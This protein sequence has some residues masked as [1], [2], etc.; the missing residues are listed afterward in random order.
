MLI[1]LLLLIA[2][3]GESQGRKAT[4]LNLR[5][6]GY[7]L[8]KENVMPKAILTKAVMITATLL[9]APL[10][11]HAQSIT[12][13]YTG[14]ITSIGSLL[15]GDGITVGSSLNGSFTYETTASTVGGDGTTYAYYPISSYSM[16]LVRGSGLPNFEAST[17]PTSFNKTMMVQNDKQNGSATLPADGLT[18]RSGRSTS[19]SLN[20][21]SNPYM[22]T[23]IYKKNV[24]GHLWGDVL[25]PSITD[26]STVSL[27]DFNAASWNWMD[28]N[29][30]T[31]AL[32]ASFFDDQIRWNIDSFCVNCGVSEVP[33]PAAAF[34]FA[35]ALLG[36]LGLR[37][38][39]KVTTA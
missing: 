21:H 30:N 5:W 36:F 18:V 12:I 8:I 39:A 11:I 10:S 24:N 28:F 4:D 31:A 20:G 3:L 25:S 34:M 23:G 13:S 38:K 32:G 33:V 37:R 35:P 15:Q 22:Q 2:K 26:W 17:T 14:S 19:S 29:L 16:S 6:L 27:A 1:Y 7:I 9:F